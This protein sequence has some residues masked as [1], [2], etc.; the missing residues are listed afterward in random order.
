ML[1]HAGLS[2][3]TLQRKG[4]EGLDTFVKVIRH[5]LSRDGRPTFRQQFIEYS[6]MSVFLYYVAHYGMDFFINESL[7]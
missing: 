4:W 5:F 3:T 2:L 1:K 7:F 6:Q